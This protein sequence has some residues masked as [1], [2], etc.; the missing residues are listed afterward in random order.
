MAVLVTMDFAVK[1]EDAQRVTDE[2]GARE[3]PP[4]GLIAH[5]ATDTGGGVHVV[6][7]WESA[8]HFQKFAESM[9]MPAAQKVMDELGMTMADA[10]DPKI[11]EAYDLVVGRQST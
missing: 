9:L 3:N 5:V 2:M 10:P 1:L 11:E 7:I 8:E 4:E 6:D